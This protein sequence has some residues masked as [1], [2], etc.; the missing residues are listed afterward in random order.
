MRKHSKFQFPVLFAA[1]VLLWVAGC[2]SPQPE[3]AKVPPAFD[4]AAAKVAIEA[5]S[6]N[7]TEAMSKGDAA[8]VAN[9]YTEDAKFMAPNAPAVIGRSAIQTANESALSTGVTELSLTLLDLWGDENTLTEE[10]TY[11]IG[12]KDGQTMDKGK[13]LVLWKNVDGQWKLHRDMFNSDNPVPV[14]K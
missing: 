12:T 9:C 13:Y 2:D 10:G 5:A 4:M 3:A 1:F 6:H 14:A 11:T 7:F 8:A